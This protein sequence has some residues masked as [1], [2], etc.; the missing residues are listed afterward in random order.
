MS[1]TDDLLA[2]SLGAGLTYSRAAE[3]AG[4]SRATRPGAGWPTRASVRRLS[5]SAVTMFGGSRFAWP[6]SP[7]APSTRST[8]CS[9]TETRPAQ[10]L[11]AARAVLDGL[12]RFREVGA[13]EE[14]LAVLEER[15]SG[16]EAVM[17]GAV[18]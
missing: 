17:N 1:A 6:I 9:P 11:G 18:R 10:R 14:R 15:L 16:R 4:I 8:S 13:L 3:V 2:A 5:G 12:L 7:S